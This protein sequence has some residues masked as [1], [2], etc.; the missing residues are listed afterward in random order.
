MN[1]VPDYSRRKEEKITKGAA[2]V[3]DLLRSMN[4]TIIDAKD[5]LAI[6]FEK[7]DLE[8]LT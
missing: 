5:I 8:P 1:H 7:L 2:E 6:V 3:L 4:L